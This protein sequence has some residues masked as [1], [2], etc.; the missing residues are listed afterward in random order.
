MSRHAEFANRIADAVVKRLIAKKLLD[1]KSDGS[2]RAAIQRL[3]VEN[4]EAEA[5]LETEARKILQEHVK[6]IRDAP[7]DYGRLLAMVKGKLA[8]ERGVVL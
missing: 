5:L 8:R 6:E 4:F 1:L 7:V 3:L 2:A